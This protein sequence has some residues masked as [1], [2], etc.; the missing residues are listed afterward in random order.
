MLGLRCCVA[1]SLVAVSGGCSPVVHGL[2]IVRL[3]LLQSTA[4]KV[5]ASETAARGLSSRGS[6]AIAETP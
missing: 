3:F 6:Q 1:F 2:P 4:S 5:Q